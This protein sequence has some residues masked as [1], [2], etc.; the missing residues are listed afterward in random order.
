[1]NNS[2]KQPT[3]A[4]IV[5]YEEYDVIQEYG[6]ASAFSHGVAETGMVRFE[7]GQAFWRNLS[8]G[9]TVENSLSTV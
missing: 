5:L 8:C 7:G 6:A 9:F 1:L 3:F 2:L 4:D